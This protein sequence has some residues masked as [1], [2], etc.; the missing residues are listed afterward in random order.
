MSGKPSI[1]A[2]LKTAFV[3]T[4]PSTWHNICPIAATGERQSPI[5]L[6]DN[7]VK[8][9]STL[10]PLAVSYAPFSKA[11]F[12]NNGHSVQFQPDASDNLSGSMIIEIFDIYAQSLLIFYFGELKVIIINGE[13]VL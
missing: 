13:I 2:Q 9:D 11:K 6:I 7:N 3:S 5:D 1:D 4:G 8:R 10:K 12:L